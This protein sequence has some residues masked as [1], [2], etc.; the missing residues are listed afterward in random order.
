MPNI[1]RLKGLRVERNL[2]QEDLAKLI[3]MPIT[4][5]RRK[6]NGESPISLEEAYKIATVLDSNMEDIFF[7]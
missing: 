3:N 1:R 4:T 7:A 2:T 6:E 5:Y